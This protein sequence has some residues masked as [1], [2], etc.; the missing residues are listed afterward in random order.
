MGKKTVYALIMCISLSSFLSAENLL[1]QYK[2]KMDDIDPP[3]TNT[4]SIKPVEDSIWIDI[5]NIKKMKQNTFESTPDFLQ[6]Q[7]DAIKKLEDKVHFFGQKGDEKFSFGSV[8][9]KSYDA[10]TERMLLT[11]NWDKEAYAP[12]PELKLVHTAYLDVPRDQARELFGKKKKHYFHTE[13]GYRGE[14]LIVKSMLLYNTYRFY[15]KVK[16]KPVARY[17]APPKTYPPRVQNTSSHCD[18]YY[19]NASSV[20][21]RSRATTKSVKQD[22]LSKNKKVCVT[23]KRGSWYYIENKG[24]VLNKFLQKTKVKKRKKKAKSD[25][26]VWHC[27]ARSDRASGWVER[28]GKENA[29]RGAIH[30]CTIRLQTSSPCRITNCYK[31]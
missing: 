12:F 24:W 20:N 18:Y 19:T 23:K 27:T 9:M 5:Q 28:V 13:L 7:N 4:N 3:Q 17:V 8:T 26:S 29:K 6:R 10:D 14:K 30:Q 1:S 11:V 25:R 21:V 31:L 16:R 2:Q 22:R 15:A